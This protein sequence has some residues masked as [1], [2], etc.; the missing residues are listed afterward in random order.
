MSTTLDALPVE[1]HALISVFLVQREA[2]DYAKTCRLFY[3]GVHSARHLPAHA[4]PR[5]WLS[6]LRDER[7]WDRRSLNNFVKWL[8]AQGITCGTLLTRYCTNYNRLRCS[9]ALH[10]GARIEWTICDQVSYQHAY[11]ERK[12]VTSGSPCKYVSFVDATYF[13][14]YYMKFLGRVRLGDFDCQHC[15]EPD[16]AAAGPT[17][18]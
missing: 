13:N 16:P 7:I 14:P 6:V 10:E 1:L 15:L 17:L 12:D 18:V 3:R 4:L 2:W 11:V 9:L 8:F 5:Q